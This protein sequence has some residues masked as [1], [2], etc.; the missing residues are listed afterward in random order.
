[1]MMVQ[2]QET[3]NLDPIFFED[4][5][6][7]RLFFSFLFSFF[8]FCG[9]MRHFPHPDFM[10]NLIVFDLSVTSAQSTGGWG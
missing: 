5:R 7:F 6:L 3:T 4:E 10:L 1:M 9:E 8:F 2:D